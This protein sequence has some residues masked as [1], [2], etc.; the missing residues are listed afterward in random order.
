MESVTKWLKTVVAPT[1][2]EFAKCLSGSDELD[3]SAILS[4]FKILTKGK[5]SKALGLP[6]SFYEAVPF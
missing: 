1:W 5:K 2:M 3:D 4:S 6:P